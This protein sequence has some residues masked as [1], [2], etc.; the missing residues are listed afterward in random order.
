VDNQLYE[1]FQRRKN[2]IN[3]KL[4]RCREFKEKE[5]PAVTYR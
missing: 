4:K 5:S 1:F 2:V 3:E